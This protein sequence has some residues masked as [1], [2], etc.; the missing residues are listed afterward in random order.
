[1]FGCLVL[2]LELSRQD[3]APAE[4]RSRFRLGGSLAL[5]NSPLGFSGNPPTLNRSRSPG[6]A[7]HDAPGLA[8][9][10]DRRGAARA[11]A[12]EHLDGSLVH[13]AGRADAPLQR[14]RHRRLVR[15]RL[16]LSALLPNQLVAPAEL[17]GTPRLGRAAEGR[18]S[19]DGRP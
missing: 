10:W 1:T 2:D 8:R 7:F 12:G 6:D 15:D 9:L 5:P 4:P 13:H 14:D 19:L 17:G 18:F 3:K 11:G 16:R